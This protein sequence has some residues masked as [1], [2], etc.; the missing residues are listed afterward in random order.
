MVHIL[1]CVYYCIWHSAPVGWFIW[2]LDVHGPRRAYHVISFAHLCIC[3]KAR[4]GAFGFS[5]PPP[6]G[7]HLRI[8]RLYSYRIQEVQNRV[9][10]TMG[11][12]YSQSMKALRNALCLGNSSN[13]M[14]VSRSSAVVADFGICSTWT[15]WHGP[16]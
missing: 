6:V 12:R 8:P 11:M 9:S 15:F 2:S 10:T 14:G 3:Q 7:S 16:K 5:G 1:H 13:I 4:Y